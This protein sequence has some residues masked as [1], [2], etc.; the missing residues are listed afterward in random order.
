MP[1]KLSRYCEAVLEAGWIGAVVL[2][3]LFFN[4][5]SSRVFEPDKLTL[6]RSIT[7]AMLVAWLAKV[8]DGR[9][10]KR[11][12]SA[13][14]LWRYPMAGPIMA[15]A[16][17]YLLTTALSITPAVSFIGSYQRL[18]GTYTTLSYL[19]AFAMMVLHLRTKAQV[20]RLVSTIII[21]S[22]PVSLYGLIQRYGLDPLPWGGDVTQRIASNMGNAIFV[23]AYLIMVIPLLLG[24]IVDA[25]SSILTDEQLS[26]ADVIRASIY[27]FITAVHGLAVLFSQSRGPLLGLLAG[28][29]TFALVLLV[30]L[31]DGHPARERLRLQEVGVAIGVMLAIDLAG[32]GLLYLFGLLATGQGWISV[33]SA[34]LS[35]P[36]YRSAL[37][38]ALGFV[39]AVAGGLAGIVILAAIRKGWRWLW[40]DLILQAALVGG[41]LVLFNVPKSPISDWRTLPYIGRIGTALDLDANTAKVRTYIWQGVVE[42]VTPHEPLEFPDNRQDPF[43]AIRPLVGYGPESMYVS[44]NRFY[45]PELAHHEKRNASPDRSHNETFDALAITGLLGLVVWQTVYGSLIYFGLQWLGI[46]RTRMDR[47]WFFGLVLGVGIASAVLF[48]RWQGIE[49]VGVAFPFG[50]LAGLL[51]YLAYHALF[52]RPAEVG[53]AGAPN[54]VLLAAL[55]AAVVGHFAE[56]HFGIAI[57]ATRTYFFAY[58][59]LAV[60]LG[61]ALPQAF[62]R[63]QQAAAAAQDQPAGK[64]QSKGKRRVAVRAA[65]PANRSSWFKQ[66]LAGALVMGLVLGTL[67]YEFV[68]NPDRGSQQEIRSTGAILWGSLTQNPK[69]DFATTYATLGLMLLTAV[70]GATLVVCEADKSDHRD[71][72]GRDAWRGLG[73]YLGVALAIGLLYM[74]FQAGQL[75]FLALGAGATQENT[76]LER[77]RI[78]ATATAGLLGYFYFFVFAMMAALGLVLAIGRPSSNRWGSMPAWLSL[79]GGPAVAILLILNTNFNLIAADIVYKQA[80][81]WDKRASQEQ[82]ADLWQ[83]AIAEYNHAL[84][85]APNEDFYYLWLG[86]AY[87]EQSSVIQDA[88]AQQRLMEVAREKLLQA[89][90]ISP[91]NT[92]HSANLARLH[93]RWAEIASSDVERTTKANQANEYYAQAHSLSP[94]NAVILNEWSLLLA[95]LL[96]DCE[97]ALVKLDQSLAIDPLYSTTY[98]NRGNV[99]LTCGDRAQETETRQR[100]YQIARDSYSQPLMVANCDLQAFTALGY[101]ENQLGNVDGAIQAN[102]AGLACVPDPIASRT[103]QLHRN[104]AILYSQKG[105]P[106]NALT[107]AQLTGQAAGNN[108]SSLLDAARLLIQLGAL[109]DAYAVAQRVTELAPTNWSQLRELAIIYSQIG[110]PADGLAV[111]ATA[112]ELAPEEQKTAIQDLIAALQAQ[113]SQ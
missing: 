64:A 98:L 88:V 65:V 12:G 72:R 6:L 28:V 47:W 36:A 13:R 80:D 90:N 68:G 111:A 87:L 14:A 11:W 95:G 17:V 85:L 69:Q 81:P 41:F 54:V 5:Y 110:R 105:D 29:F 18:Q 30:R 43:N 109:P 93:T 84:E 55:L 51:A 83:L 42:M 3:P 79:L 48:W 22:V 57:A 78:A 44:Y 4:V 34:A 76:L 112:L 25:F 77:I 49:L 9:E 32:F 82:S 53:Q 35:V 37:V 113:V 103:L 106:E 63:A 8:V 91:L 19:V 23:S 101:A 58:A 39:G 7:L 59:A 70:L 73:M 61:H 40:L 104:L 75:R 60:V 66:I 102:L 96:G 108:I 33:E 38:G 16:G 15:L 24:R 99:A 62:A 89:R 20:D 10:W 26:W 67:G 97:G 56:I 94:Q 71:R 107:H 46:I 2:V 86:R 52:S 27:I 45:V 31:R 100:Y 74:T 21:A 92:D 50:Q 1:S